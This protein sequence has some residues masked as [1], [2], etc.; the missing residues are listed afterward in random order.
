MPK[1]TERFGL[2]AEPPVILSSELKISENATAIAIFVGGS[3][4]EIRN[5]N[6]VLFGH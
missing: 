4:I 1:L 5:C 2:T 6:H 3:R